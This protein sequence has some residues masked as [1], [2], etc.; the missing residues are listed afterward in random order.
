MSEYLE[1]LKLR[2]AIIHSQRTMGP[3]AV[4]LEALYRF[5]HHVVEERFPDAFAANQV[6]PI[7]A[8]QAMPKEVRGSYQNIGPIGLSCWITLNPNA[9]RTGG[10]MAETLAHELVHWYCDISGWGMGHGNLWQGGM[11]KIGIEPADDGSGD[12]IGYDRR[13]HDLHAFA[14]ALELDTILLS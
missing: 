10:D 9:F 1:P 11:R 4:L 5:Q 2:R 8:L 6:T 13:W 14:L 7:I 3:T 12:H